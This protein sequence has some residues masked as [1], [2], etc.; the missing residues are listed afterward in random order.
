MTMKS[1]KCAH[2]VCSCPATSGNYCST[3]C[4]A[5]AKTPQ[6]ACVCEHTGCE[7]NLRDASP[8]R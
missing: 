5:M 2:P 8:A 3:E 1:E 6:I 7:G 4:E